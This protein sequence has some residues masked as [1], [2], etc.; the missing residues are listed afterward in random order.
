MAQDLHDDLGAGLTEVNMLG[1]LV[2][3]PLTSA[4][5]KARYLDQ[6][7]E[8]ARRLVTSLDEIVWAVNPR[9]DSAASL[10]SYFASYTQQFLELASVSCGLNIPENLPQCPLNSKFRH[11]LFL[12]FKE[13]LNNL[14]RHSGASEARLEI[15]I[16]GSELVL[17]LVD[18]GRGLEGR[19]AGPGA[20]GLRNMR[21]RIAGL[22]GRCDVESPASGGT[23]VRFRVPLP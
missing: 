18:N 4:G 10:A 14:A 1:S 5:E 16:E 13:A 7:S 2:G 20:D 21:D 12:A 17:A 11:N 8:V 6:L 19:E 23:A 22:G 3:N 15:K 9:N